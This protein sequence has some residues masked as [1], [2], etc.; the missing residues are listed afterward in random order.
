MVQDSSGQKFLRKVLNHQKSMNEFS[1]DLVGA[2]SSIEDRFLDES[3]KQTCMTILKSLAR[4]QT[5]NVTKHQTGAQPIASKN[6][7]L[8]PVDKDNLKQ[9]NDFLGG[10]FP[11]TQIEQVYLQNN[12][13][14]E[15]T[16]D[17]FLS[18]A[19]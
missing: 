11:R 17:Q 1:L 13:N 2:I 12:K 16:L 9:I 15:M 10:S 3:E 7:K 8:N 4:G 5:V 6:D 18:G 19:V 14:L